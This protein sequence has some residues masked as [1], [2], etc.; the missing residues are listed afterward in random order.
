MSFNR[1]QF[2]ILAAAA[3]VAIAD[4]D[5]LAQ[6]VASVN[7]TKIGERRDLRSPPQR[8]RASGAV[9]SVNQTY[10]CGN[11]INS[12]GELRTTL[13]SLD[14]THY[15][16]GD[17]PKFEVTIENAGSTPL[18]IP[19]S[20]HLGDLQPADLG[21]KFGYLKLAVVLWIGGT[22]WSANTGGTV[23]LYGAEDHPGTVLTL[24]PGEWV[25][26]IGKG[27][28][29]LPSGD[30]G[31]VKLINIGD[32]VDHANARVALSSTETLLSSPG[33]ATVSREVCPKQSQGR[34]APITVIDLKE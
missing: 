25:R 32:G 16:I 10:G 17:Q 2:A 4:I 21:K 7:L 8:P 12:E 3:V 1:F 20:P 26:V 19:F 18:K 9:S 13:V 31:V 27:H 22:K 24:Q 6:E 29:A 30:D 5:C 14:R 11:S 33:G 28:I 34:D 15:R 23:F